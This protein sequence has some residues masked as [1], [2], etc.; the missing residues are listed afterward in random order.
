MAR[1]IVETNLRLSRVDNNFFEF[2][3]TDAFVGAHGP[4]GILR[5]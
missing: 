1:I 4:A 5:F 3:R 2:R